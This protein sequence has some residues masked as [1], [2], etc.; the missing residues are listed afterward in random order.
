MISIV[1]GMSYGELKKPY[2]DPSLLEEDLEKLYNRINVQKPLLFETAAGLGKILSESYQKGEAEVEIYGAWEARCVAA[3]IYF[4]LSTGLNV[5]AVK[6]LIF[7]HPNDEKDLVHAVEE[8]AW[9]G[10]FKKSYSVKEDDLHYY[11]L[12]D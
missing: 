6:E 8:F 10:N 11:F 4:S 3:A 2:T 9:N 1:V 7:K 5:K 12:L